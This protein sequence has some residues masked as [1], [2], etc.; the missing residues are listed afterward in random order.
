MP[1]TLNNAV[2]TLLKKE[3]DR[4]RASKSQH[5]IQRGYGLDVFPSDHPMLDKWRQSIHHGVIYKDE[6]KGFHIYGGIDDLWQNEVEEYFVVDYKA[7]AKETPLDVL[8]DYA[9]SY[10]RQ[11]E[12][13]QWLLR[14]NG[15]KVS[16]TA[17]F[18]YATGD[19]SAHAFNNQLSFTTN[20][21]AYLGDDSWVDGV[22]KDIHRTIHTEF[23]PRDSEKCEFCKF[24]NS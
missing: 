16:D 17:Y 18:V 2:D 13:Y 8:P 21:I 14:K 24:R 20:L 19:T 11:M 9:S 22:I 12:V 1:Y 4:H 23:E 3:F 7:T 6:E 5:P 10:R 15:L